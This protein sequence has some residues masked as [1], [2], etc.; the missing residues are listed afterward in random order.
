MINVQLI[1]VYEDNYAYLLQ[2]PCGKTA[3]IDPG[4]AD[5]IIKVLDNKNLT[6]DYILITHHHWD[7][8]NGIAKLKKKYG[9][10]VIVPQAEFNK[11][12]GADIGLN[13]K[14]IFELGSEKAQIIQTSGHT[15]GA[16][17]YYFEDSK[18]LFTGDTLF[19]LGCGRL[20]EGTAKDMFNSLEKLK[21]LPNDTLVYCGHEYTRGNA[22]FCLSVEPNNQDLRKRIEQVK[23]L[24]SEGKPTIPSTIGMEK[25]TNIFLRTK[26]ADEFKI[27]RRK[28]DVF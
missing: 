6:L 7:H 5:P 15:M 16:I 8:V 24:R 9:C 13:D 4:E 21:A 22:G 14:D 11:I 26:N 19:S 20:F 27:I 25:K 2:S 12:K 17:C 23:K 18:A 28:K 3:I 1:P 10:P